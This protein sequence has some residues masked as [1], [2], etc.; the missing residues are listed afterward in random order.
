MYE[1]HL[2][3]IKFAE[4]YKAFTGGVEWLGMYPRDPPRHKIYAADYFGQEHH[5]KTKETQFVEM[6]PW[7]ELPRIK[8]KARKEDED[9]PLKTYR[10]S[11]PTLNVTLKAVSC[12]PRVF[13]IKNFIS[14]AEADH[15]L[16]LANRTHELHH[17]K[18]GGSGRP[19]DHD[20]TR[21]SL[22]TWVQREESPII[23][24][25]YRRVADVLQIDEAL[26]RRRSPEEHPDLGTK[27]SI[28]EQLQMVHY[29]VGQEY[30]AHHDF[31]Y[32]KMSDMHQ[33]S[34][35]INVLLYLND[36][37]EGGEHTCHCNEIML[38]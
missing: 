35:S 33:P 25:I 13:E 20:G 31:G 36:V 1:K 29:D 27:S 30:T 37:E 17:S 8:P 4:E 9:I 2:D 12:A 26:L 14:N 5:V 28:A 15:I 11:N 22:N 16:M 6:P 34:R 38:V 18:T 32:N 7:E 24:T 21:T 23:D 19:S 10:S 3:N